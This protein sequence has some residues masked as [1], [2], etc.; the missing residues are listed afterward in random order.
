[1]SDFS[2]SLPDNPIIIV[3]MGS[4]GTRLIVRIL[5]NCGVFMGGKLS[6][7][8]YAEPEAFNSGINAFTDSF[9]YHIPLREDWKRIVE[10]ERDR[11]REF[12][13]IDLP[14]LY[15]E[16][17]YRDG[18]WG[19]KDP[20]NTFTGII[21]GDFFSN[22]R[23]LHV[24]RD[25]L[26]VAATKIHE[27]WGNLPLN[28]SYEYWLQVWNQVVQV[29]CGYRSIFPGR[30]FEIRY[31]DICFRKTLAINTISDMVEVPR[32]D[33]LE[34]VSKIAHTQRICKLNI[35]ECSVLPI[36]IIRFRRRLGYQ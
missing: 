2:S 12:C 16:A 19:F 27:D 29:G 13:R 4:S 5:E 6:E 36:E 30:Y 21:Y 22:A 20:R 7:N 10:R 11:I 28:R 1:M 8:Q 32:K 24:I 15:H 23:I 14:R 34:V 31:E 3:G 25:G 17:G 35:S 33:V 26:D 9:R 18:L